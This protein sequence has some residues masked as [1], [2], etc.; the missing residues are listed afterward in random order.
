MHC[1]VDKNQV[2]PAKIPRPPPLRPDWMKPGPRVKVADDLNALLAEEK[3]PAEDDDLD[4]SDRRPAIR[5]YKSQ[6]ILGQLY[7]A[8]D[9]REFLH[10]SRRISSEKP[11]AD[12]LG[13]LWDYVQR[14]TA[15]FEWRHCIPVGYQAKN[16]YMPS[17]NGQC[18][19]FSPLVAQLSNLPRR[20]DVGIL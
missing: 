5:Y 15:M 12:V 7:R 10:D 1:K 6:R 13:A 8:I 11:S 18:P 9:E 16:R 19:L 4:D 14:Q 2:D 3:H 20:A 17:S